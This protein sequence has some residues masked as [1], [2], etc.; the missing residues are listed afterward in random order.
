M[1]PYRRP[2]GFGRQE[3]FFWGAP[4][5]GGLVGGLV[6]STLLNPYFYG[7]YPYYRPPY[8]PYYP[9]GGGFWY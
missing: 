5:V 6:G 1:G 2:Y 7:G 4:L 9:Y 3:R 8:Y